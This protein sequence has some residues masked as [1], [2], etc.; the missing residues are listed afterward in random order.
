MDFPAQIAQTMT[1]CNYNDGNKALAQ[2]F[3]CIITYRGGQKQEQAGGST[4][5]L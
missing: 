3:C 2:D 4:D 1:T 5:A